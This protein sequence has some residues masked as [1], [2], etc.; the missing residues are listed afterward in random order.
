MGLELLILLLKMI[1]FELAAHYGS[2]GLDFFKQIAKLKTR[3]KKYSPPWEYKQGAISIALAY[4]NRK[5]FF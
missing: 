5:C 1:L 4:R 3:D 2:A